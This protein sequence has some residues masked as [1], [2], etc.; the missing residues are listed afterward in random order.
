MGGQVMTIAY[1]FYLVMNSVEFLE[2]VWNTTLL[3]STAWIDFMFTF[4]PAAP[5]LQDNH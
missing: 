5:D 2:H 4:I 1:Y 3:N